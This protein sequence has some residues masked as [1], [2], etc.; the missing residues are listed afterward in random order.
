MMNTP[1]RRSAIL[2]L[3]GASLLLA[4]CAPTLVGKWKGN[5]AGQ[6][7]MNL[8]AEGTMEFKKDGTFTQS[9]TAPMFG[10]VVAS[11]TY[12]TQSDNVDLKVQDVQAGGKSVMAMIPPGTKEKM[13]QKATWKI[14]DDKLDL[15]ISGK[16]TTLDK[17]KE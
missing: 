15:T 2:I 3:A 17:V 16:T 13:N 7:A 4:G 1:L 10:S 6:N 14:H 11:G 8:K 5:F 12:T 9:V